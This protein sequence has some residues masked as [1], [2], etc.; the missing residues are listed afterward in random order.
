MPKELLAAR[1]LLERLARDLPAKLGS[2]PALF[3]GGMKDFAF[4]TG[5]AIPRM[6]TTFPDHVLVEL[7]SASGSFRDALIGDA[8]LPGGRV[9]SGSVGVLPNL[10]WTVRR[11]SAG[12]RVSVD[13][14]QL[15]QFSLGGGHVGE[16]ALHAGTSLA[17]VVVEQHGFFDTGELVEQFTYG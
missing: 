5:W 12:G 6:R 1:P 3:V 8:V 4:R 13:V 9:F 7:P 10:S 16:H 2:K 15:D 11:G 14:E 17:A